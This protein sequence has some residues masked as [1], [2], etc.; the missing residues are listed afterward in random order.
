MRVVDL[1]LCLS[2]RFGAMA[3]NKGGRES[4]DPM[5]LGSDQPGLVT[6]SYSHNQVVLYQKHCLP[7]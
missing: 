1:S 7:S 5:I 6:K 4:L 3:T 2:G